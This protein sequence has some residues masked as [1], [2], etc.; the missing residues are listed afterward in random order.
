LDGAQQIELLTRIEALATGAESWSLQLEARQRVHDALDSRSASWS[1]EL[2]AAKRA[3][4]D[5]LVTNGEHAR[6]LSLFEEVRS[7]FEE[8]RGGADVELRDARIALARARAAMGDHRGALAVQEQVVAALRLVQP[9]MELELAQARRTLATTMRRLGNRAGALA[10]LESAHAVMTRVMGPEDPEYLRASLELAELRAESGNHRGALDLEVHVHEVMSRARGAGDQQVLTVVWNMGVNFEKLGDLASALDHKERAHAGW[11][12]LLAHDSDALLRAKSGLAR[13]RKEM[14][15]LDGARELQEYVHAT[16]ASDPSSSAKD[17]VDAGVTLASTRLAT[18]DVAGALDLLRELDRGLVRGAA[19]EGAANIGLRMTLATAMVQA[20][21]PIGAV[22]ITKAV[23]GRL[24]EDTGVDPHLLSKVMNSH[25]IVLS[26]LG[27][28]DS[29]MQLFHEVIDLRRELFPEGHPEIARAMANLA[30]CCTSL[31]RFDEALELRRAARDELVRLLPSGHPDLLLADEHLALSLMQSGDLDAALDRMREV[32]DGVARRATDDPSRLR[33]MRQLATLHMLR[34][35]H[36]RARQLAVGLLDGQRRAAERLALEAPRAARAAARRELDLLVW[37]YHWLFE[38]SQ[39]A[40]REDL[41]SF[42][43]TLESLRAA[44]IVSPFVR[45]AAATTPSLSPTALALQSVRGRLGRLSLA[46]PRDP[47]SLRSWELEAVALS[48][49]R[50]SCERAMRDA[51]GRFGFEMASPTAEA[52]AAALPA[53]GVYVCFWRFPRSVEYE[54]STNSTAGVDGFI[55][56]VVT[57]G[58]D[59]SLVDLGP[60]G[61]VETLVGSWRRAIGRPVGGGLV[62]TTGMRFIEDRLALEVRRAVVDPVFAA[63]GDREVQRMHVV[64]DDVLHALPIDALPMDDGSVLGDAISVHVEVSGARLA[65]LS[66]NVPASTG[67]VVLGDIEFGTDGGPGSSTDWV[68]P[69]LRG[70]RERRA[71]FEPLPGTA[72]EAAAVVR[73][74]ERYAEG[75]VESKLGR[76]ASKE[77][78]LRL[79]PGARYVH[80]ATHGWF[81]PPESTATDSGRAGVSG[82]ASDASPW[83]ADDVSRAFLPEG[84]C[85]IVL[86]GANESY[87]GWLTGEELAG[88]DLTAC[89]LVVLSACDTGLGLR[90]TGQGVLSLQSA[91]HAAGARSAVT[92]LWEVSDEA[93]ARFFEVFYTKLWR[94]GSSKSAALWAAKSHLRERRYPTCDWAGWVLSG[95][96]D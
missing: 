37:Y 28:H 51:L 86:A 69:T 27:E 59:V 49:E 41:T 42:F 65:G 47:E 87:S 64:F 88:I 62:Q 1:P 79:A 20:G 4:A 30:N 18:G 22:A 24:V 25:A 93:T 31:G 9:E 91:V 8:T 46:V 75:P 13:T 82:W 80:I 33:A 50:E 72:S 6:A 29:A 61:R 5:S 66:A 81:S 83:R 40:V 73:S 3:L 15:D 7:F 94:D 2:L 35:E 39:H 92:S 32:A 77:E 43:N 54:P 26:E 84:R 71:P 78:L 45:R 19:R 36:E 16:R 34:G 76:A 11:E 10:E 74:F 48:E 38:S 44:S 85:G 58:P 21:D 56:L 89:E 63:L 53:D 95:E 70:E 68:E 96:P 12:A 52:I 14:G 55:A 23:H 57:P 17:V 90:S 60:A 67:L